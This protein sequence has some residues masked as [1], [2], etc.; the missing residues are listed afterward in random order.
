MI[1]LE[2]L[3]R[4]TREAPPANEPAPQP[5]SLEWTY[6]SFVVAAWCFTP[7]LRRLLDYRQGAFN[8]IQI[9]SLIPF[10]LMIPFA[11]VCFRPNGSR[12]CHRC[13]ASPPMRG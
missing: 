8:P 3:P 6:F 7:L 10:A 1:L 9:T 5:W 11:L 13:F 4:R 2:P 12:G